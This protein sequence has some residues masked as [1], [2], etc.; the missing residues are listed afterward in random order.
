M[1]IYKIFSVTDDAI[2]DQKKLELEKLKQVS[3]DI[4]S[5]FL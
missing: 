5:V 1:N 3:V 2:L 4:T